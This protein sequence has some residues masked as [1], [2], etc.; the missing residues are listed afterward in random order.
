MV[1][2]RRIADLPC[3]AGIV[4]VNLDPDETVFLNRF[5]N[6]FS[7]A[8]PVPFR[9]NKREAKKSARMPLNNAGNFAV[10][11]AV[12][13]MENRKKNCAFDPRF[14]APMHETSQPGARVPRAGQTIAGACVTMAVDDHDHTLTAT[15]D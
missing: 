7:H 6:Q 11:R 4:P 13:R 2:S 9:V 3:D 5:A 14:L 1:Q 12:V 10:R 15:S 8:A